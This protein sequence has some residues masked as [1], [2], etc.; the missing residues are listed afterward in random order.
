[1]K[2]KWSTKCKLKTFQAEAF[3]GADMLFELDDDLWH[4][5]RY[6]HAQ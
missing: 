5:S 2:I 3:L 4:P 6:I 1:M